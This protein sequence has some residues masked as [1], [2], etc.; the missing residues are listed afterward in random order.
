MHTDVTTN[1]MIVVLMGVMLFSGAS[2]AQ[3]NVLPDFPQ[4]KKAVEFWIDVYTV[5]SKKDVILHDIDNL[6]V[7]YKVVHF[8]D[9]ESDDPFNS[10]IW[11]EIKNERLFFVSILKKLSLMS[12]PAQL[13]S[14]NEQEMAVYKLW[15]SVDDPRKFAKA[16]DNI[17]SQQGLKEQFHDGLARSGRYMPEII[18][19]LTEYNLPTELCYLPHVESS[20]N[21]KA[22]SKMGAAG[23]WQ[24]TRRTG[25]LFMNINYA[26]D[27]RL[28]PIIATKAA[29]R[30][31]K[32][33]YEELGTWPLA[34]TAYNHGLEG[35]KRAKTRHGTND[36]S[37]IIEKYKSRSFGFASKNFYAEFLAA[38]HVAQNYAQY[39]GHVD[40]ETPLKFQTFTIP[41]YVTIGALSEKFKLDKENIL[42]LNPAFRPPIA[43]SSRRIPKGFELKLP[44]TD[45]FDA[46]TLYASLPTDEKHDD[47]IHDHYYRVEAGD[48]LNAIARR[49]NT[50]VQTIMALN[51]ISNP[52]RIHEGQVLEM[53]ANSQPPKPVMENV[54]AAD[55]LLAVTDEI[56][57]IA[58]PKEAAAAL[59]PVTEPDPLAEISLVTDTETL[60]WLSEATSNFTMIGPQV[61]NEADD[62]QPFSSTLSLDDTSWTF[63]VDFQEPVTDYID[64]QPEETIGHFADWL[65]VSASY[66]RKLNKLSPRQQIQIGQ[67]FRVIFQRVSRQDFHQKRLEYHRSVQEDF[68]SNFRIILV[69]NYLVKRGDNIWDLASGA[70]ELPYWLLRRY[71]QEKNLLMLKPGEQITVPVVVQRDQL[72]LRLNDVNDR[73]LL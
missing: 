16:K 60:P 66:L 27:E 30:L 10:A 43:N 14:L 63:E 70:F 19:I 47:Q 44:V 3:E 29:A 12:F 15:E 20:F 21:Y 57:H 8:D 33:N 31:L 11:R 36:L 59:S 35:M 2:V 17:R 46:T 53:P 42:R 5:Y 34:I 50:S 69:K 41:D 40:F 37:I 25:R 73:D 64:V 68:F 56:H 28:D 4:L 65:G 52:H 39:F 24:F 9:V 51:E 7:I 1:W 22:Y 32:K 62:I 55:L 72:P 6:D 26:I 38:K 58:K 67:P 18:R 71:N 23:I 13:S 49:Y 61:P 54:R 48:N 45:G